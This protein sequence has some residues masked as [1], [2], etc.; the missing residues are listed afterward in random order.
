L[1]PRFELVNMPSL[2]SNIF[3]KK[4][5]GVGSTFYKITKR[6]EEEKKIPG[7]PCKKLKDS[8]ASKLG[9]EGE[10]RKGRNPARGR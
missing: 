10:A 8:Q 6:T 9:Q 3:Q 1:D 5:D 2:E 4:G 7:D